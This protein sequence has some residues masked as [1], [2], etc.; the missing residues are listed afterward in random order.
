MDG[1]SPNGT[2]PP[3]NCI[4]RVV[5]EVSMPPREPLPTERCFEI[6]GKPNVDV[7]K[8]WFIKEGRLNKSDIMTIITNAAKL[9][10]NEDNI[11][12]MNSPIT[13]GLILCHAFS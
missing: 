5:S 1:T 11:L 3:V 2:K 13:G 4:D 8:E 9:L 10:R 6:S 12:Y 7:I